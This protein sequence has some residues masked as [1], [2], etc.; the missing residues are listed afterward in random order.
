MSFA[1]MLPLLILIAFVI[2]ANSFLPQ[3]LGSVEAGAD[4]TN[5]SQAYQNQSNSTRDA[6]IVTLSVTR[7][8]PLLLG[9]CALIGAVLFISKRK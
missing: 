8:I 4:T 7:Y 2:L 6:S 1:K 5:M 9:V 3:I